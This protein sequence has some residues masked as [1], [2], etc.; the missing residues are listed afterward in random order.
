MT[1]FLFCFPPNSPLCSTLVPPFVRAFCRTILG[2][3]F[4]V[5]EDGKG[6]PKLEEK[7]GSRPALLSAQMCRG[8]HT[9]LSQ[10]VDIL[11]Q[12]IPFAIVLIKRIPFSRCCP[13]H[14]EY[15]QIIRRAINTQIIF[16]TYDNN[17]PTMK[18]LIR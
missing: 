16:P 13:P 4:V 6:G 12:I 15:Y 8:S 5:G 17:E 2:S 9:R 10:I 14:Q 1:S 11:I 18:I 3:P 7:R